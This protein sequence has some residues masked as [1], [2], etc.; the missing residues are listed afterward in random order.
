MQDKPEPA[1]H[2]F[3]P[4]A[5]APS[6]CS[7]ATPVVPARDD[8]RTFELER[9][10]AEASG[11]K[12]IPSAS[13]GASPSS[14]P[15]Y[16]PDEVLDP[17]LESGPMVSI[18]TPPCLEVPQAVERPSAPATVPAPPRFAPSE[19]A[20][21]SVQAARPRGRALFARVL[22]VLLFGGV[23]S[24]LGYAF[25]SPLTDA[26]QRVREVAVPVVAR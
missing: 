3:F 22:F 23:A 13:P 17:M 18:S 1:G 15:T 2:G 10:L 16:V 6:F 14:R 9:A 20:E 11:T 7:R 21:A 4:A 5:E 8:L 12:R 19:P 25:K 24:L 26:A